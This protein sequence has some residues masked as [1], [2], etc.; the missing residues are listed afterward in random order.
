MLGKGAKNLIN[1]LRVSTALARRGTS[2]QW[3][4]DIMYLSPITVPVL[5]L[6]RVTSSLLNGWAECISIIIP[7]IEALGLTDPPS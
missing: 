4:G 7:A 1:C 6:S 2:S 5:C 3:G